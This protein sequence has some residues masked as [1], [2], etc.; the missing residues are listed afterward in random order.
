MGA[1]SF[2][3]IGHIQSPYAEKFAVPRQPGL[4]KSARAQLVLEPPFRGDALRGIE[5]FS[6]LWLVFVF[7]EHLDRDW[8]P[9]VRP[10]RL[11]GNAKT[12]VFA[13]RSTFRPN[14]IGLSVVELL[15]VDHKAGVLSLGGVDLVDGTPIL[16]IKPYIPYADAHPEAK[17]GYAPEAP[18]LLPVDWT[19]EA[20]A[21]LQALG[22]G[23]L[24]AFISEVLAQDPRPA[25]KKA[26]DDERQYGVV[27]AGLNVRFQIRQDRV[28]VLDI[29]LFTTPS[30]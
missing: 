19:P 17:G 20:L 13:S 30:A 27:L 1:F 25:Y 5:A 23:E 16:D 7:H 12:G 28:Q 24:A 18:A 4:V 3:A 21:K 26:G 8:Q 29:Q 2:A 6:H 10:P 22:K 15:D 14:P 9:L 11:G